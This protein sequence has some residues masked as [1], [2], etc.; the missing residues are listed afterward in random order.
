M[1][2]EL[3]PELDPSGVLVKRKRRAIE[4]ADPVLCISDNT[5]ATYSHAMILMRARFRSSIPEVVGDAGILFDPGNPT[6]L[7]EVLLALAHEPKMRAPL[8]AAVSIVHGSL[9]GTRQRNRRWTFTDNLRSA[10]LLS[11]LRK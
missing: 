1:I 4:A 9:I 2:H 7:G 5:N 8:I 6:E 3:F 11:A 10:D